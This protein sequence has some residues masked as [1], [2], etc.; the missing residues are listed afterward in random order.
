MV[1]ASARLSLL[2]FLQRPLFR[3]RHRGRGR[4][5]GRRRRRS[6]PPCARGRMLVLFVLLSKSL[7]VCVC[8]R[9][10]TKSKKTDRNCNNIP[11]DPSEY[12][13][14]MVCKEAKLERSSNASR[15]K[16]CR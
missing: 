10:T 16:A 7:F 5:R 14:Q 1:D 8:E 2:T 12:T 11:A 6:P 4:G 3:F 15:I 13:G 9:R